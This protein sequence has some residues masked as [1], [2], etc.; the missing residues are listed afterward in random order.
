MNWVGFLILGLGVCIGFSVAPYIGWRF[1]LIFVR[2][3]EVRTLAAKCF[4]D[5]RDSAFE[6]CSVSRAYVDYINFYESSS[7]FLLRKMVGDE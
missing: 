2:K 3:D 7:H 1:G 4:N 5:G 6:Q